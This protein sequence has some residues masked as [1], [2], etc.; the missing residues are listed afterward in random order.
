MRLG[1]SLIFLGLLLSG[2]IA[3]AQ[4]QSPP[5][6]QPAV[7]RTILAPGLRTWPDYSQLA[8][9]PPA[10][11]VPD[12]FSAL[13]NGKDLSGW[14]ISPGSSHG[15]TP[16][17]RVLHGMIVGTQQPIG[18]GGL[19]ISDRKF[20]DFELYMEVKPDWGNDSGLLFRT[21]E[22]GASYQVTLDYLPGGTMGRLI[23]EGG[24]EC[25]C[26]A[27][28]PGDDPGMSAWKR[29]DWNVVRITV[30]SGAPRVTVWI[31]DIKTTDSSDAVNHAV[32]GMVEGPIAIQVHGGA[33]RWQP[34]GY[35]RW[36]TI[37]VRELPRS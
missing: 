29:D 10:P 12:G 14:H 24:I 8:I 2:L 26:P 30:L 33:Q 13:F 16:D 9:E 34:G 6:P 32:D 23:G 35:W 21:N 1:L 4:N 22:N 17:Y 20:R 15:R 31:N 28:Q 27:R 5:L 18:R 3:V 25:S 11:H 19:L 7:P 36:R 37:A